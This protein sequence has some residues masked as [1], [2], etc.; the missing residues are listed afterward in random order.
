MRPW[1][2]VLI[3]AAVGVVG[4]TVY[5]SEEPSP[6]PVQ[7]PVE[8]VRGDYAAIDRAVAEKKGSVVLVDFWAT[9]CGPCREKF[10][11]LVSLH[12]RYA[13]EG[14][15][16]I[17]VCYD[18]DPEDREAALRMLQGWRATFRNF[19]F[20]DRTA[21][22]RHRMRERFGIAGFLPHAALFARSGERVWD[23]TS[24]PPTSE[25]AFEQHIIDELDK[26]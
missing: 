16:C 23:S 20:P 8:L 22:D 5:Y 26:K 11:H 1:L 25:A 21:E 9:T 2:V 12:K 6:A 15:V 19:H 4:L 7:E 13:E 14:L 24:S 17:S 10:P 3:L 18:P